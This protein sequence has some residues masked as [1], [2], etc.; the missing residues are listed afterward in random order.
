LNAERRRAAVTGHTR[1]SE[2]GDRTYADRPGMAERVA[3]ER[4][5]LATEEAGSEAWQIE[6]EAEATGEVPSED[7]LRAELVQ[8]VG[9]DVEVLDADVEVRTENGKAFLL[10]ALVIV[11]GISA[12]AA[13]KRFSQAD[14]AADVLRLRLEDYGPIVAQSVRRAA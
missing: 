2:L 14:K 7:R 10:V 5:R 12:V 3:A 6:L 1:W 11:I 4:A 13:A 9:E 8:A